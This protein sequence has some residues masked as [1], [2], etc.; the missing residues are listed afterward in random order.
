MKFIVVIAMRPNSFVRTHLMA[1]LIAV[2]LLSPLLMASNALARDVSQATGNLLLTPNHGKGEAWGKS[3]CINCHMMKRLHNSVPKIKTIVEKKGFATCTGCHGSNGTNAQQLCL[4]CHNVN[5]M[6]VNP[7][8]TGMHRHDFNLKKDL[9]TSSSQCIVCHKASD[10]DGSFEI[11]QDLT[12]FDDAIVGTRAY[13]DLNDFCLRCHN[14]NHQQRRWPIRNPGKRD[15]SIAAEEDYLYIDKHGLPEGAAVEKALYPGLR[16]PYVYKSI[17]NCVDCHTMHG[18]TNPGLIIDN[19]LKGVFK[20]DAGLRKRGYPVKILGGVNL[21][22]QVV[23][24]SDYSQLCVLCHDMQVSAQERPLFGADQD[25]GN[26]LSGVHFND[27]GDCVSCH[28]HGERTQ[29]GL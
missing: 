12:V 23:P 19:S 22:H 4:V 28:R 21:D 25:T 27:G 14:R 11:Q 18:T 6:P 20:L 5:D 9:P 29:K 8:R 15:Q 13:T 10:M 16:K 17:V 2:F 1:W 7:R 24:K 26:G 3:R